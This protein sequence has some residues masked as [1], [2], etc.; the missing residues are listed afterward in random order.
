MLLAGHAVPGWRPRDACAQAFV[1]LAMATRQATQLQAQLKGG[2][3][4]AGT[5]GGPEAT[6]A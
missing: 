3:R 4:A 1:A 5:G 6:A 2:P